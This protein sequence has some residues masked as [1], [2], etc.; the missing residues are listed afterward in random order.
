MR[1]PRPPGLPLGV[2]GCPRAPKTPPGPASSGISPMACPALGTSGWGGLDTP[3]PCMGSPQRGTHLAGQR[4]CGRGVPR[5]QVVAQVFLGEAGI[6][7]AW[8]PTLHAHSQ[9]LIPPSEMAPSVAKRWGGVAL[10][11]PNSPPRPLPDAPWRWGDR[12]LAPRFFARGV[13][14]DQGCSKIPRSTAKPRPPRAREHQT[15]QGEW[16]WGV[17]SQQQR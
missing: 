2:W 11:T 8:P 5:W 9:E 17:P 13:G 14:C 3:I 15:L 1:R 16:D 4:G 6:S 12:N 7:P 10:C